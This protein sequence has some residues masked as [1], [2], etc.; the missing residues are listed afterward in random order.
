VFSFLIVS[1]KKALSRESLQFLYEKRIFLQITVAIMKKVCYT[2]FINFE[3]N[4]PFF[5][6]RAI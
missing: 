4:A 2:I 5:A 3:K 6:A 1:Q